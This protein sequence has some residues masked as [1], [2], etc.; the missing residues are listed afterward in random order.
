MIKTV[1]KYSI[2]LNGGVSWTDVSNMLVKGYYNTPSSDL[3]WVGIGSNGNEPKYTDTTLPNVITANTNQGLAKIDLEIVGNEYHISCSRDFD[4]GTGHEFT[5]RDVGMSIGG[6]SN[7]ASRALFRDSDGN[8]I[9][10]NISRKDL[11]NI[12]YTLTYIVPKTPVPISIKINNVEYTGSMRAVNPNMWGLKNAS[13]PLA[14][15]NIGIAAAGTWTTNQ[16]GYIDNF[17][18]PLETASCGTQELVGETSKEFSYTSNL[19][20]SNFNK[21]FG[22]IVF[23]KGSLSGNNI[24]IIIDLDTDIVNTPNDYLALGVNIKQEHIDDSKQS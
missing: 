2:S 17:G 24:V 4:L 5:A 1:G 12:R 11:V 10:I 7:L 6:A 23:S 19:G 22:Q 14:I 21:T 16:E 13:K 15:D 9:E 20:L 3:I 18:T 8:P